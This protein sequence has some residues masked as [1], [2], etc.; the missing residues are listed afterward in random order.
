M[1]VCK[2]CHDRDKEVLKCLIPFEHHHNHIKSI[3]DVC[4]AI[5]TL[6][7][8]WSYHF[9]SGMSVRRAKCSSVKNAT[10]AIE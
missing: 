6:A 10:S 9:R 3:C 2:K 7:E 8:C 4:G 5:D 1:F